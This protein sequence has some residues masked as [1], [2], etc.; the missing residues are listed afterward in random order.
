VTEEDFALV[1]EA[2]KEA[3][4]AGRGKLGLSGEAPQH[5]AL[6]T[7]HSTLNTQHS[8]TQHSTLNTQHLTLNT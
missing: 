7:Q 1:L 5:S 6:N 4:A 3:W 2:E 8:N